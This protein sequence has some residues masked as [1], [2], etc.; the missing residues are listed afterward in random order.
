MDATEVLGIREWV[1][2]LAG[3]GLTT[4]TEV[5][6][7][8]ACVQSQECAHGFWSLGRRTA[9]SS[10][11][12]VQSEFDA[13]AFVRTHVLRPTW[14]FVAA[15]DLLWIQAVTRE[16][17]QQLNGTIYRREGLGPR[18][19]DRAATSISR[20][21]AGGAALTRSELGR[22]LGS[23]GLALAYSIMNAEL[24]GLICSGP[25]RRAQHT[26]ALVSERISHHAAGDGGEL[27]YRFFCGHG[28][29]GVK[30]LARW[31]SLTL[32][33]SAE[34]VE[35]VADR[36]A[37]DTVGGSRLWFDPSAPQ[38]ERPTDRPLLLPL[39][40]ELTLS[41][42]MINFRPAADHPH[43]PGTD[44]FT[45]SVIIGDL[46]VG[47][48]RRT[49]KGKKMIMELAVAPRITD[50]QRTAVEQQAARMADFLGR[51]LALSWG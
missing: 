51:T 21:L 39:Y 7:T 42:P 19:L 13:G 18:E 26:Y 50:R 32:K 43:P 5:V 16:R 6:R 35:A 47:T 25:I 28:P 1:H 15:E 30:D 17:V 20:E 33:Q 3:N 36:L 8:L 41:Y 46:D 48:W 29:A 27:A 4:A 31:S 49:V 11:A 10:Y 44:R 23:A 9:G 34:A 38:R 40:D 45:G 24:E 22:V 37:S 12:D 14:H 2:R